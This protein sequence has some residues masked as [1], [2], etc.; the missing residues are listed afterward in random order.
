MNGLEAALR[1]KILE[2]VG[3]PDGQDLARLRKQSALGVSVTLTIPPGGNHKGVRAF[4][5]ARATGAAPGEVLIAMGAPDWGTG[6]RKPSLPNLDATQALRLHIPPGPE[7]VVVYG[8]LPKSTGARPG[9]RARFVV[10]ADSTVQLDSIA[11]VPLADE[12]PPPPP[13]PWS[14]GEAQPGGSGAGSE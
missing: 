7:P 2:H 14:P 8:E 4:V 13:K 1:T 3:G 9:L 10:F 12:L 6:P 11:L 5:R